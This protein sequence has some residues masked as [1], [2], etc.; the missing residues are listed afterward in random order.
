VGSDSNIGSEN[1]FTRII[2]ILSWL[3]S[4]EIFEVRTSKT[5][6]KAFTNAMITTMARAMESTIAR[7]ECCYDFKQYGV[8]MHCSKRL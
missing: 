1:L 8:E 2:E 5:F 4:A 6:L 3:M 7:F